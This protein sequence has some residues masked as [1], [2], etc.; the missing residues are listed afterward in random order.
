MLIKED[1]SIYDI[2][3]KYPKTAKVFVDYGLFCVG[4]VASSVE[5]VKQGVLGHGISE[6]IFYEILDKLNEVVSSKNDSGEDEEN[7][8]YGFFV[9]DLAAVKLEEI[10]N[11]NEEISDKEFLRVSAKNLDDYDMEFTNIKGEKDIIF[12]LENLKVIID[13]KSFEILNG[14]ELGYKMSSMGEGFIF[15]RRV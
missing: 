3:N 5:T 11:G 1:M 13:K 15:E 4:C 6:E 2:T 12:Y 9:S 7:D 8:L 10:K 14:F